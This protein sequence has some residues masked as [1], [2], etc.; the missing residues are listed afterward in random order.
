MNR[1]FQLICMLMASTLVI[2]ASVF[3]STV[4]AKG[5][6]FPHANDVAHNANTNEPY[7]K[8]CKEDHSAKDC[9]TGPGNNGEFTS[10]AAHE[11]NKP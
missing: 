8:D 10:G 3:V 6:N 1:K 7:M 5:A 9:A 2:A 4:Y 11:I